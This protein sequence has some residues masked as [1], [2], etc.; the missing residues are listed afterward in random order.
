LFLIVY[1]GIRAIL[2]GA[3]V[4]GSGFGNEI[5]PGLTLFWMNLTDLRAWA[6][7]FFMYAFLPLS[8]LGI[9]FWPVILKKYLV[10]VAIPWFIL[11][12]WFGTAHETR[13]FLLPLALVFIPAS[14]FVIRQMKNI[15]SSPDLK[16][17]WPSQ[18]TSSHP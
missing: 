10:G 11:N 8:V 2:G 6:N 3:N 13:L 15:Y 17:L 18:V 7:T 1:L 4:A 14:L 5:T 9:R 16:S 12:Y